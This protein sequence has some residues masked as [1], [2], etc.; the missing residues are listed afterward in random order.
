[1]Q[2]NTVI[3]PHTIRNDGVAC[4]SH[5]SGTRKIKRLAVFHFR[6]I[7]LAT[8]FGKRDASIILFAPDKYFEKGGP[9]RPAS[10]CARCN[11]DRT[12]KL[13]QPK[14]S[15]VLGVFGTTSHKN[16]AQCQFSK[17]KFD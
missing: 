3:I 2:G 5:A 6:L 12:A 11:R 10:T 14:P 1:M 15:T 9:K 17:L 8:T 4:S 16:A 7:E 13:R